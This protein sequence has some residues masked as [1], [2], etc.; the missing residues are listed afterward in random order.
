MAFLTTTATKNGV[1]INTVEAVQHVR[2]MR[3]GAQSHLMRCSDGHFYVV[4]FSNNP[5]HIRVLANE[6]LATRLAEHIGLPVPVV[7]AV[8]VSDWLIQH[9]PQ[10]S[11]QLPQ[12]CIPCASGL[13]FGSRYI[14]NPLE[15][16]VLDYI[17]IEMMDR[18]RNVETFKGILAFDKWVGNCDVRQAAYGRT[19]R[20]KKY[21]AVFID[22][23]YC[24]NAGEW[25]FPDYPLRGTYCRN[26]VYEAVQGWDS[27]EPWLSR[28]ETM[29][30]G[31]LWSVAQDLPPEWYGGA[32]EELDA[33]IRHVI[34]RRSIVRDLI[35]A[36]RTSL[37]HPF[38]RWKQVAE[39]PT[40]LGSKRP[41]SVRSF[42]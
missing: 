34:S 24:F 42:A 23:G 27:F 25:T 5:Q 40:C 35:E 4:K 19:N 2:P 11:I 15:G 33:L 13:Q 38:P 37:R 8:G 12:T 10:L 16:Q 28:I 26:E 14:V 1:G 30:E 22:Q 31:F 3:G 6:M 17:P 21:N 9:T 20:K 39:F 36:F 29:E 41:L 18:V 32:S 7:A